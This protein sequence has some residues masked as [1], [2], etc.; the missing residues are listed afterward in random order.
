MAKD[1]KKPRQV[2]VYLNEENA[3]IFAT[4][5]DRIPDLE[6]SR[7][8]SLLVSA[9]LRA[10]KENDYRFRVP[11]KIHFC[12]DAENCSERPTRKYQSIRPK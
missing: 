7:L 8:L 2:R 1:P 3:E 9:V 10:A 5:G 6:D 4:L 11:L 12:E